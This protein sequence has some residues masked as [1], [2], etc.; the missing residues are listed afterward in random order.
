MC[1][2]RVGD[3]F[4]SVVVN[5]LKA[6]KRGFR[7]PAGS[8]NLAHEERSASQHGESRNPARSRSALAKGETEEVWD[9]TGDDRG[10]EVPK[11]RVMTV[12]GSVPVTIKR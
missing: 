3:T 9:G 4:Y 10:T 11:K 6:V 7:T 12:E 2:I 5:S 8:E 1:N